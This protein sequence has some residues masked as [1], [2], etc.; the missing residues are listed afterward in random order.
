MNPCKLK[1]EIFTCYIEGLQ[2][3]FHESMQQGKHEHR[4]EL[5]FLLDELLQQCGIDREEY[6]IL[7]NILAK[8]LGS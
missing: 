4:N 7:N 2:K 1:C 8:S 3:R 6:A 5:V